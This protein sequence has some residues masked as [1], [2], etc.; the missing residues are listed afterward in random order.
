M[1]EFLKIL[2]VFFQAFLS[3]KKKKQVLPQFVM[4]SGL[5]VLA[6]QKWYNLKCIKFA[7][8]VNPSITKTFL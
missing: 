8:R 4:I 7:F 5:I 6:I 3:Q 2:L 1:S